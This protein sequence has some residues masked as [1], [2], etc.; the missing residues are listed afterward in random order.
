MQIDWKQQPCLTTQQTQHQV[1]T[2]K[3]LVLKRKVIKVLEDLTSI[4]SLGI[5]GANLKPNQLLGPTPLGQKW[6]LY[7]IK[8]FFQIQ[9][10]KL[11]HKT[12]FQT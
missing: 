10:G 8:S 12:A 5:C 3:A 7:A 1:P 6:K 9:E 4:Q 11:S 2:I